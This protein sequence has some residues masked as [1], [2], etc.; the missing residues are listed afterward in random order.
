MNKEK[1]EKLLVGA[2][3]GNVSG[4]H[5]GFV[6]DQT[7][8][9]ENS[10]PPEFAAN[11]LDNGEKITIGEMHEDGEREHVLDKTKIENAIQTYGKDDNW[12]DEDCTNILELAMGIEG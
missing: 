9:D 12:T 11:K 5:Y 8:N 4:G 6:F 3:E 7:D 10:Y 2:I 1:I